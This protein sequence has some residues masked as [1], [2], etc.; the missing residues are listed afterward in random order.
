[1]SRI[2]LRG[3]DAEL[4]RVM[5]AVHSVAG[6]GEGALI[7]I[8]GEPGIGKSAL[9]RVVTDR[10]AHTGFVVGAGKA[11]QIDQIA[12]GAPLLVALRSGPRPLLDSQSFAS[13]AS[14]YD[15]QL[16]L[17]ERISA[18]LEDTAARTP[19]VVAIDDVQ[20]ADRLTRFALR[21]LPGRLA[22]SPVVWILTSRSAQL[23][24]AEELTS[25][26]DDVVPVTHIALGATMPDQAAELAQ[27]AFALVPPDHPLWLDAGQKAA[28]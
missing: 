23:Q 15:R 12:P 2:V 25:A 20:W 22:A 28:S 13:V 26:A 18:I 7:A 11:D 21:I 24:V 19:V 3:R 14:L 5:T 8:T 4:A 16:W 6:T 9:L 10:A 27:E 1:M 17:V